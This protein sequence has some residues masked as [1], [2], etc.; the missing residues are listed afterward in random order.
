MSS[1]VLLPEDNVYRREV[2]WRGAF[3][4]FAQ[5]MSQDAIS[6]KFH[7]ALALSTFLMFS[8][9]SFSAVASGSFG[10]PGLA[11]LKSWG[12]ISFFL[13]F[14][15]GVAYFVRIISEEKE[16]GTL[17]LLKL[18][19]IGPFGILSGLF[20]SRLAQI[21]VI[22][23][24]QL[25]FIL[26]SVTLGG[27]TLHQVL[28]MF[29]T[30]LSTLFLVGSVALFSAVV[31]QGTLTA[32]GLCYF[33]LFTPL[34]AYGGMDW[35]SG[36]IENG[37]LNFSG[38]L[39][40]RWFCE[41]GRGFLLVVSPYHRLV[42]IMSTGYSDALINLQLMFSIV[43][44]MVLFLVSVALFDA[45]SR[46][47]EPTPLVAESRWNILRRRRTERKSEVCWDNPYLWREFQFRKLGPKGLLISLVSS[48]WMSWFLFVGLRFVLSG[49]G[50]A[51]IDIREI[52]VTLG[53]F[54]LWIASVA[55]CLISPLAI[56]S[57]LVREVQ[58]QTLG[59]MFLVARKPGQI[60]FGLVA[61]RILLLLHLIIWLLVGL[62][63]CLNWRPEVFDD[64]AGYNRQMD[65]SF[66]ALLV[67]LLTFLITTTFFGILGIRLSLNRTPLRKQVLWVLVS[68]IGCPPCGGF[69][70]MLLLSPIMV[71]SILLFGGNSSEDLIPIVFGVIIYAVLAFPISAM[72]WDDSIWAIRDRMSED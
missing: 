53:K 46:Q 7:L 35:T 50:F 51:E 33:L 57:T 55:T 37:I 11:Y 58:Q 5:R 16:Q 71:G 30:L 39:Q 14:I 26:W 23:A 4:L 36:S 15:G 63:G 44:G 25:P 48:I 72:C 38:A 27:V 22:F 42:A 67:I 1:Q 29:L 40:A 24:L 56:S 45:F 31:T 64:M 61:G 2:T 10:A 68:M 70:V 3:A 17:A 59:T 54:W 60:L 19:G 32:N 69:V 66:P 65:S 43:S 6:W 41:Q 13:I 28:A 20:G 21:L 12:D 62:V 8:Q 47:T 49:L 34:I 9:A 18:T 52:G